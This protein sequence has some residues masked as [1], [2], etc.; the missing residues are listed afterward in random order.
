MWF[1]IGFFAFLSVGY[2]LITNHILS[3]RLNLE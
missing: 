3:K 1:T 2:F